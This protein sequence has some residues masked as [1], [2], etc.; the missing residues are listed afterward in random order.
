MSQPNVPLPEDFPPPG[1]LLE[2]LFKSTHQ[3]HRQLAARLSDSEIPPFLTGP[4]M[5][6]LRVVLQAGEIRM[7]DLAA[8]LGI[9][10][11]TVTQFVDALE[12]ENVIVRVPDP[13]DRRATLIR[14]VEEAK[15][16]IMKTAVAMREA[17]EAVAGSLPADKRAQL[18]ELLIQLA[19]LPES[20]ADMENC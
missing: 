18:I 6:F 12:Q 10:A 17:S 2:T 13:D 14:I 7:S 19:G 9:K 3:I 15:P 11:R 20:N 8:S 5:R 4:R 1:Y 16:I